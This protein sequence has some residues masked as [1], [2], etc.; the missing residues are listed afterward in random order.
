MA[1]VFLV[2]TS[3]Q[4]GDAAGVGWDGQDNPCPD[5]FERQRKRIATFLHDQ[6]Q[7]LHRRG[8]HAAPAGA[9]LG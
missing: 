5:L 7:L 1:V 2:S 6:Y 9:A 3:V 8:S 4:A